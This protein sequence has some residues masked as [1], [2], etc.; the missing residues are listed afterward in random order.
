MVDMSE[1]E[2]IVE[3]CELIDSV[4][5][6][7]AVAMWH[8]YPDLAI[9]V[10]QRYVQQHQAESHVLGSLA[11]SESPSHHANGNHNH[12]HNHSGLSSSGPGWDFPITPAYT[13]LLQIVAMCFAG[14]GGGEMWV[15]MCESVLLQ[16]RSS[17]RAASAYLAAVCQFLLEVSRANAGAAKGAR[18]GGGG[19]GGAGAGNNSPNGKTRFHSII[20]ND[21]IH[22][23][24]R[25]GF[26]S[27][28]LADGPMQEWVQ[29]IAAE[30]VA[31]GR[32][33]GLLLTGIQEDGM[34]IMQQYVNRFEDLQT[35][36]LLIGRSLQGKPPAATDALRDLAS[37]EQVA[38]SW[39]FEYRMFLNGAQLYVARA[40]LDVELG[41]LQRQRK[42][43][44]GGSGA[45]GSAAAASSSSAANANTASKAAGAGTAAAASAGSYSAPAGAGGTRLGAPAAIDRRSS[46][47]RAMHALPAHNDHPHVFL[48]CNFCSASL[49]VDAMQQL[50]HTAFLRKQ[51]PVI[52]F[53][54]SC[55]KPLPRCYV[56]QLYVGL[57]NPHAEVSRIQSQKRRVLDRAKAASKASA[58]Q[59]GGGTSSSGGGGGGS[60]SSSTTIS[61]L[62]SAGA[63]TPQ[64]HMQDVD[65]HNVLDFGRWLFF[66][67]RC[68]HGG[69]ASCIDQ[70]F[71]G[72]SEI[73]VG[74]QGRRIVCGVNGCD[75]LCGNL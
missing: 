23:E 58:S 31:T 71:E 49:P 55:K 29:S 45:S 7:A 19:G 11:I 39:M 64:L 35:V 54:A 27:F 16:L 8:G 61:A 52:N 21:A 63:T 33:Q 47:S 17:K 62:A 25:L 67:Q 4:E 48:R 44:E 14:L 56:C 70:W 18:G 74:G 50:Q 68:K 60:S 12:N 69:H 20:N 9:S 15:S 34:K 66:C 24:D 40:S 26:A 72:D 10:L 53:C 57:V 46:A 43:A 2:A 38:W 28:Y 42:E 37:A 32:L 59:G 22:L 5:R 65:D 3:E 73:I 36:A 1:L 75:C 51:K 30:S 41:R 6:A 13:Q